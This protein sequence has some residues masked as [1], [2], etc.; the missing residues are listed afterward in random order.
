MI[1][2]AG[3]NDLYQIEQIFREFAEDAAPMYKLKF[4]V[5][6]AKITLEGCL[7]EHL[8][9]VIEIDGKIVGG[10][11]GLIIDSM[12]TSDVIFQDLFFYVKPEYVNLTRNLIRD[13]QKFC[14]ARG[15]NKMVLATLGEN[16]RLDRFYKLLG[17]EIL[18][19]HFVKE[20]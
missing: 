2:L 17:F 19:K 4:N 16:E 9:P 10:I 5:D 14:K 6:K 13:T 11:C 20:I 12:M 18:E 15:V 7:K 3:I 8:V 1:R